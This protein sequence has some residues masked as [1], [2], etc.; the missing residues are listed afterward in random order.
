MAY[1]MLLTKFEDADIPPSEKVGLIHDVLDKLLDVSPEIILPLVI[2]ILHDLYKNAQ[3]IGDGETVLHIKSLCNVFDLPIPPVKQISP[4]EDKE[5]VHIFMTDTRDVI[6]WLT[7]SFPPATYEREFDNAFIDFI[8]K[9]TMPV[10]GEF[11]LVD[12]FTSVMQFIN[13]SDHREE[14]ISIFKKEMLEARDS[15]VSG[16]LSAMINTIMGFPGIPAFEGNAYEHEKAA[17]F[18][19]LNKNLT[20]SDVDELEESVNNVIKQTDMSAFASKEN[21]LKILKEYTKS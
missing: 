8:E 20:F 19:F 15:C 13:K 10:V 16:H 12:I 7:K 21:L 17:V 4:Y 1:I 11:T 5:S 14:L 18:N 2:P 6:N 9:A 3:R